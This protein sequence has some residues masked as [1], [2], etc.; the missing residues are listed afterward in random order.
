MK[1]I[2]AIKEH[3]QYAKSVGLLKLE[4]ANNSTRFECIRCGNCCAQGLPI[5]VHQDELCN[6]PKTSQHRTDEGMHYIN[7]RANSKCVLLNGGNI[8]SKYN[9]RP[10]RCALFPFHYNPITRNLLVDR[11]CPG[12]GEGNYI[13]ADTLVCIQ[14]SF[15]SSLSIS[16]YLLIGICKE[17][18]SEDHMLHAK[19][20]KRRAISSS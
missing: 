17:I 4:I 3:V 11:S 14:K 16:N 2:A 5:F 10:Q 9:N 1:T 13:N 18:Y 15:I 12:V 8:C 6:F 7:N 19:R 20:G